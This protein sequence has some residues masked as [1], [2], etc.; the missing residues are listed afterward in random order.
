MASGKGSQP[1]GGMA[2]R[3]PGIAHCYF[4]QFESPLILVD[5]SLT[6][7][8]LSCRLEIYSCP[9]CRSRTTSCMSLRTVDLGV[10]PT[11]SSFNR[12]RSERY[13]KL[14][15]ARRWSPIPCGVRSLPTLS[16]QPNR[17]ASASSG[18]RLPSSDTART[19]ST[20]RRRK[21]KP[22]A[23]VPPQGHDRRRKALQHD[24]ASCDQ[25]ARKNTPPSRP[26][27]DRDKRPSHA[28]TIERNDLDP[29]AVYFRLDQSAAIKQHI[30][31][32]LLAL[33]QMNCKLLCKTWIRA[34]E[35][36]K[37][38]KFPYNAQKKKLGGRPNLRPEIPYWWPP[39]VR[40][41]E[42][43]HLKITGACPAPDSPCIR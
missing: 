42:P 33:Q 41:T 16:N 40:H 39:S 23:G 6:V 9:S 28:G 35:P 1:E 36:C 3:P 43:D 22:G 27:I 20:V 25:S 30:Q 5:A 13:V 4:R 31:E 24:V 18:G 8:S 26:L 21:P 10:R 2:S 11:L 37:Q 17:P 15:N 19:T 29:A 12:T 38:T 14:S 7:T 32:S 34:F